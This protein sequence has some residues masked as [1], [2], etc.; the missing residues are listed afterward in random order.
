MGERSTRGAGVRDREPYRRDDLREF[1]EQLLERAE[2]V[3]AMREIHAGEHDPMVIGLRH[4]VDNVL[5]PCVELADW[6]HRHGF[7]ATYFVLHDSPY[8]DSPELRP[9]LE[10]LAL[11]G[12][13]IG[14]HA[15]AIAVSLQTGEH[16]DAIL[17]RALDRLRSWGHD[18]I[19][20]AAHGDPLC[21]R[22]RFVNDEQFVECARPEMGPARRRLEYLGTE[23]ELEP[24]YLSAFGLEYESL[25][26][27]R[28]LYLSDSGG[29]WNEPWEELCER[30]PNPF[31]QLHILMHPCWWVRAFPTAVREAV[32]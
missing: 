11:R 23:L 31:G 1:R 30:F 19:G 21:Y 25:R 13:E 15:N 5:E 24:R 32:A 9:A 2:A 16:P 7:R 12:H 10:F 8:W 6:E 29:Q 28:A 18:V 14:I 27:P 20:V 3:V 26:L 4:D 17:S 22:A